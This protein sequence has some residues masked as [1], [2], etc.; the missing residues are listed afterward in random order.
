MKHIPLVL[1]FVVLLSACTI[2]KQVNTDFKTFCNTV[3]YCHQPREDW[4]KEGW[5]STCIFCI[6]TVRCKWIK[7]PNKDL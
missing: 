1:V 6:P 7:C 3:K 5:H 4:P 2:T